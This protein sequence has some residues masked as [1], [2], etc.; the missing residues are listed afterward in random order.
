MPQPRIQYSMR[1]I[2]ILGLALCL[3]EIP[4]AN[5]QSFDYSP[6]DRI[7]KQYVT[8]EG[9]VDYAAL[10][11]NRAELDGYVAQIAA[12]SPES[13]PQDFSTPES[14]L[15]Y[16]INAYNTLTIKGVVDNWPT[17]SVRD[18]GF[19]FAF[20]RRDDYT[21]GGKKVSLNY[22]EHDVIRKKFAEPRIHFALVC[23][24]LGC[25]KLRREAYTI[26]RLEEQ[27]EDGARYFLNEPRNLQ[28]DAVRN[29]VT[30]SKIFDWYGGDFEKHMK[31]KGGASSG[32]LILDYVRLYA[33][34]PNRRALDGLKKPSVGHADYSWEV[35]A[36]SNR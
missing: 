9:R 28:I 35:N 21:V 1:I 29:R 8:D 32:N 5:A 13:H 27:L 34:D 19:L 20:F 16:W 14:Q 4:S 17:K 11:A 24:S 10:K 12:R 36:T 6:W 33:S 22:I 15:A 7:L 30:I 23:A 31:A 2:L 26:E 25:P 18:L 3:A